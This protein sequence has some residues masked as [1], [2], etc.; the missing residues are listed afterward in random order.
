MGRLSFRPTKSHEWIVQPQRGVDFCLIQPR[1]GARVKPT[2]QAVG[3][4]SRV[5]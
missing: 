3:K 4:I 5:E 2:A 1:S